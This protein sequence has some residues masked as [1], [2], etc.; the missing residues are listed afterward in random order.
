[1]LFT[2]CK[3][4][5]AVPF[6]EGRLLASLIPDAALLPLDSKNHILLEREPAWPEFVAAVER[7]TATK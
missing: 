7:F 3:E 6:E 4:E 1:M 2:H 5:V